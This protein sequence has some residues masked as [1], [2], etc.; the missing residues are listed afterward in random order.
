MIQNAFERPENRLSI[1][2]L[3]CANQKYSASITDPERHGFISNFFITRQGV[4][5]HH[6]M[7][8]LNLHRSRPTKI[9]EN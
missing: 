7:S 4:N 8:S 1:R 6:Y 5:N 9:L 3:K 2:S